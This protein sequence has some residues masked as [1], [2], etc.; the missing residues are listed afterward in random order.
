M[1]VYDLIMEGAKDERDTNDELQL[2]D[3]DCESEE[4]Q[5]G[6][7][8]VKLEKGTRKFD[9]EF[10]TLL[11]EYPCLYDKFVP[12]FHR[13]DVKSNAWTAIG[14][15]FQFVTREYEKILLKFVAQLYP[16]AFHLSPRLY[17]LFHDALIQT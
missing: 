11:V 17:K 14:K 6:E 12:E 1:F 13:K 4:E 15:E 16:Q 7:V 3:T 5:E 10:A 8:K 2:R 9:E